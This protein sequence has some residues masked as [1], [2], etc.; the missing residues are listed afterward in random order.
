MKRQTKFSGWGTIHGSD[1]VGRVHKGLRRCEG[2][3]LVE[4]ALVMLLLAI[5]LLGILQFGLFFFIQHNMVHAAR[6][7]TRS[8]AIREV[9]ATE[10]EEIALSHLADAA[11][12]AGAIFIPNENDVQ[13]VAQ[14]FATKNMSSANHGTV[15]ADSDVV[16][17]NWNGATHS[18]TAGGNPLNAV[19]VIA[20]RAE[21]NGNTVQLF[22]AGV[23]GFNESDVSAVAIA[24]KTGGSDCFDE[25]VLAGGQVII[26]QDA[27]LE[28]YCAYGGEG[29]SL[30]QNASVSEGS[31][32]GAPEIAMIEFGQDSHVVPSGDPL[33]EYNVLEETDKQP[34]AAQSLDQIIDDLLSGAN[35]PPQITQVV[36]MGL[37]SQLPETLVSGT[38]YIFQESISIDQMYYIEDVIIATR[39]NISFG[40]DA[41]IINTGD[42]DLGAISIGLFAGENISIG[43]NSTILGTDII[44]GGDVAIGQDLVVFNAR[45]QAIGNVNLGQEPG[46]SGYGGSLV[47]F[48][49]AGVA[50]VGGAILAW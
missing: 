36:D 17:G 12:S 10:A 39:K 32:I 46:P 37:A 40:Q 44:S 26:G 20:R 33:S 23:L 29:V 30:G 13:A 8:L 49:S 42:P 24:V 31:K 6:E 11:A 27:I 38:A 45:I 5:I 9:T 35:W 22:F 41:G 25:G 7:G 4:M 21:A 1:G 50:G 2:V 15:L 34:A 18:F 47:G 19:R 16:T 43:Q 28:D 14:E 3:A 48:G